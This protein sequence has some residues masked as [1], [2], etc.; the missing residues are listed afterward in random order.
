VRLGRSTAPFLLLSLSLF[1]VHI[2][3]VL[4]C[5]RE[6]QNDAIF[7]ARSAPTLETTSSCPST[8]LQDTI[9]KADR[10]SE[11]AVAY[12]TSSVP[13]F[14]LGIAETI[15]IVDLQ[16]TPR[17]SSTFSVSLFPLASVHWI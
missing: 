6:L 16:Y 15:A 17:R 3:I 13:S 1:C 12:F 10:T 9:D 11:L 7:I 14:P 2:L 4:F 5:L 8:P